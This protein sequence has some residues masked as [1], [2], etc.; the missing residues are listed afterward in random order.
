MVDLKMFEYMCQEQTSA[1][2]I[3]RLY[4]LYGHAMFVQ[5]TLYADSIFW[6]I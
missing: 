4:Y 6:M 2:R 1:F 5:I 3:D